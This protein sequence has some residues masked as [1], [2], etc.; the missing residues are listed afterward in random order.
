MT[1][2]DAAP[3]VAT[4]KSGGGGYVSIDPEAAARDIGD[5]D[6]VRQMARMLLQ[7]WDSH[8]TG[9]SGALAKKDGPTLCRAAHTFKGLLAMFHAEEARRHA[10]AIEQ[11]AKEERWSV[12]AAEEMSLRLALETA[13][14]EL[15]AFV[16]A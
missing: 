8:V 16:G 5:T 13:R 11:A 3:V 10:L 15:Q 14:Q 2:G 6:V 9:I 7:Q 1:S 4:A 12:A